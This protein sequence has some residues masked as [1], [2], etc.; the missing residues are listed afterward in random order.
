MGTNSCVSGG[1]EEAALSMS[2]RI[3]FLFF[4]IASLPPFCSLPEVH[5]EELPSAIETYQ[6]T[7]ATA[8][9]VFLQSANHT[10]A[11]DVGAEFIAAEAHSHVAL[12][13]RHAK[14]TLPPRALRQWQEETLLGFMGLDY[15]PRTNRFMAQFILLV[16]AD[17]AIL[18]NDLGHQANQARN[19]FV[20]QQ[21]ARAATQV[22]FGILSASMKV[23]SLKNESLRL[24]H[25][26]YEN[27]TITMDW[28]IVTSADPN[29][30][31][32]PRMCALLKE[33]GFAVRSYTATGGI[34][35]PG[36][37]AHRPTEVTFQDFPLCQ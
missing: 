4:M 5:G 2:D 27:T 17:H 37:A 16:G 6:S 11:R 21:L 32:T 31:P 35:F 15:N 25:E 12:L 13:A 22:E 33:N 26:V 3:A 23:V 20:T 9:D 19:A 36:A 28:D 14:N 8:F 29:G 34:N 18:Q 10:I 30:Q 1:G 7:P 24:M